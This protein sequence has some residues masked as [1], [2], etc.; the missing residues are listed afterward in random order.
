M[1]DTQFGDFDPEDAYDVEDDPDMRLAVLEKVVAD[2]RVRRAESRFDAR[3]T[4]IL[5]VIR[6]FLDEHTGRQNRLEELKTELE[7]M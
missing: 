7:V 2:L 4:D 5:R 3:R 1:S 6:N